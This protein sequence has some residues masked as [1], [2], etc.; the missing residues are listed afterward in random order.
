[1]VPLLLVALALVA[2]GGFYI[3]ARTAHTVS[4]D[5]IASNENASTTIALDP[6]ASEQG[7][8]MPESEAVFTGGGDYTSCLSDPKSRCKVI[9]MMPEIELSKAVKD[10][11]YLVDEVGK[12][13]CNANSIVI[14]IPA[15]DMHFLGEGQ[16]LIPRSFIDEL[17]PHI[18]SNGIT[19][20][21][22]FATYCPLITSPN[23]IGRPCY[24]GETDSYL[25]DSS[26]KKLISGAD[27]ASH[28]IYA[29]DY[30][31]T[32]W[33]NI[34]FNSLETVKRMKLSDP[35]IFAGFPESYVSAS[36][37]LNNIVVVYSGTLEGTSLV[38]GNKTGEIDYFD[39]GSQIWIHL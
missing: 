11:V 6:R 39:D 37:T 1:M 30:S 36:S 29:P 5:V 33:Q 14:S 31:K 7:C 16:Y 8:V 20:P 24:L 25:F 2:V 38:A 18:G 23:V 22:S 32:D 10:A 34:D 27:F 17:I 12:G 28:Y 35:S 9:P 15:T 21:L 26:G 19:S 3:Y 13:Y 4:T